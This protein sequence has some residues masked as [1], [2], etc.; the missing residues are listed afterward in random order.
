[1]TSPA[2]LGGAA[3]DL[4][5]QRQQANANGDQGVGDVWIA[6]T[7]AMRVLSWKAFWLSRNPTGSR[8]TNA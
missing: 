7:G 4:L 8:M 1:M 3:G 6:S 2:A 5:V